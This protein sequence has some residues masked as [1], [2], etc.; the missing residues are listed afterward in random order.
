MPEYIMSMLFLVGCPFV[1]SSP[2]LDNVN[3]ELEEE[4]T[5]R[6][7]VD[8]YRAKFCQ[9]LL[10]CNDSVAECPNDTGYDD[11]IFCDFDPV[12]AQDCIDGS[13]GCDEDLGFITPPSACGIVCVRGGG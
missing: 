11:E 9:A 1:F 5:Y 7:F 13:W 3:E 2:N 10:A 8:A 6:E 4:L 12:A